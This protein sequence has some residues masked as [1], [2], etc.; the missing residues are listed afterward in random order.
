MNA[1]WLLREFEKS[2]QRAWLTHWKYGAGVTRAIIAH[3]WESSL[4]AETCLEWS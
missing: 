2:R 4:E 3:H 1:K